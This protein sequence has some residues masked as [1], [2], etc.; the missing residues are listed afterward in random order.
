M[1]T[2]APKSPKKGSQV[3]KKTKSP[4][5]KKTVQLEHMSDSDAPTESLLD[6]PEPTKQAVSNVEGGEEASSSHSRGSRR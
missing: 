2:M 1:L 5:V 3:L 6:P 4:K